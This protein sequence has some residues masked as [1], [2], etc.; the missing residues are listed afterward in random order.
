M[1]RQNVSKG[2]SKNKLP[3]FRV[4]MT[5]GKWQVANGRWQMAD[6]G[7]IAICPFTSFASFAHLVEI[8][9]IFLDAP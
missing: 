6:S 3:F 7:L 2:V 5:E 9:M 1:L 8:G 4:E